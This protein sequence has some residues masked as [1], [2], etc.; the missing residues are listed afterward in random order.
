MNVQAKKNNSSQDSGS[1]VYS[2]EI[3]NFGK[4]PEPL[5]Q[6]EL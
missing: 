1:T 3:F 4:C 6:Q 2:S 5:G